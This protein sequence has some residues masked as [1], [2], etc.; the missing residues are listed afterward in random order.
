MSCFL[1]GEVNGVKLKPM[2]GLCGGIG[3][4]KS[5]VAGYL[6]RRGWGVIDS[7]KLAGEVLRG[8][9]VIE[10]IRAWWG[11]DMVGRDGCLDRKGLAARIFS[12]AVAR[13]RLEGL[14]HPRVHRARADL[15][16]IYL[17]DSEVVGVVE[18]CPLLYE[19]GL[20]K[21]C[22]YVV[23][24]S[25]SLANRKGRVC[26]NRGWGA[27]ELINREKIQLGVD[28][29]RK[30]ADYMIEN[31]SDLSV[32]ESRIDFVFSQILHRFGQS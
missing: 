20:D 3:S 27:E 17:A 5:F 28:I 4:G 16:G 31:D 13:R 29:K 11:H 2:V 19:L 9:D 8:V 21:G 32:S 23:F 26:K 15:L 10:E 7:D 18:D 24:V 25:A 12:D 22:D 1:F 14:V 6:D 30:K